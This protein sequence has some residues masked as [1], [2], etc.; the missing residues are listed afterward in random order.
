MHDTHYPLTSFR[1]NV[2]TI[3]EIRKLHK[4]TGLSYNLLF[5]DMIKK[6]RKKIKQNN[7][8][9]DVDMPEELPF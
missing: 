1:L 6:Y 4:T 7:R 3:A 8:N 9:E 2:L 5:A